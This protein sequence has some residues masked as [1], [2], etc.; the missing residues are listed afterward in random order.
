VSGQLHTPAALPSGKESL[1]PIG[2]ESQWA[3]SRSGR[4]GKRKIPSPCQ[5]SNPSSSTF[6][7]SKGRS[8]AELVFCKIYKNYSMYVKHA[9]YKPENNWNDVFV[10][11][12]ETGV[13]RCNLEFVTT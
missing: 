12:L 3:P 6:N 9:Q 8:D 10:Q 4:S 13:N 11:Q 7:F 2:W 5:D 1:V